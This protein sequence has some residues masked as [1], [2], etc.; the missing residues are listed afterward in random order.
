MTFDPSNFNPNEHQSGGGD[1]LPAGTFI[2][3][4]RNFKR[5]QS[6]GKDQILFIIDAILSADHKRIAKDRFQPIFE[7]VTMT[8]DA[9]WKFA[10]LCSAIG[11]RDP[12]NAMSDRELAAVVR[13]KPF[14][15]TIKRRTYQG[16]EQVEVS[17]YLTMSGDDRKAAEEVLEDR[18]VDN[19][20]GD[21]YEGGGGDS[22]GGE[23]YSA[24]D[25]SDDDIPF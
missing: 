21:S 2:C 17:R 4:V 18:A 12:F 24:S 8:A 16:T 22:Y 3:W 14:K 6:R 20:T 15:A 9:A 11:Q 25:F 13:Y 10:D 23:E 1:L 19:A 5:K 7:T